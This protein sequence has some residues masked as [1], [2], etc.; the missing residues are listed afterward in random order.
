MFLL[1]KKT[2]DQ[3][4]SYKTTIIKDNINYI[5]TVYH[6]PFQ[7]VEP[8]PSPALPF[9]IENVAPIV[10]LVLPDL[11]SPSAVSS[12]AYPDADKIL[13]HSLPLV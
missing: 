9:P 7:A 1:W 4:F 2:I 11:I 10:D 5:C 13:E 12:A 6:F 3:I 8:V